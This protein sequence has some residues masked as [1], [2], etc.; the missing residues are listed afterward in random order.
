[1]KSPIFGGEYIAPSQDVAFNRSVNLI[2]ELVETREGKAV[3]GMYGAPGYTLFATAGSGPIRQLYTASNGTLYALSGNE[4]YSVSSAG[5]AAAQGQVGTTTGPAQMTDNGANNQVLLVDGSAGWCLNT[6]TGAFTNPL[7]GLLGVKP[8]TLAYQ[9]GVAIV[10]YV[11]T[12]QWYQSNLGDLSTFQALNFSSAD[13]TPDQIISTFDI[14]REVW[15]FKQKVIEVWVNAGLNGFLFQRLQG[16]Q[17]PAGCV[18]PASVAR[19]NDSL[20]WLGGDEQGDGVVYQSQSYQAVPISTHFIAETI[21]DM[22]VISD[23][24]GFVE[25]ENQHWYYWLIFPTANR[26]FVYDSATKLWHERAAFANGQFSRHVAN[27]HAFAYRKHLIGDYTTGNIYALNEDVYTDN[28]AVHKWLRTWRGL[29]PNQ[30]AEDV[31]RYEGL[32]IDMGTGLS[33]PPGTNPHYM[34]RWS[35]DGG[36]TWSSEMWTDGNQQGN[37][38]ARVLFRRLGTT[39]KGGTYDRIFELSGTDPVPIQIAG[40]Y[41]DIS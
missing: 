1:M 38:N 17:I 34:L 13:S 31:V 9:D 37:T 2:P 7:P 33:V 27:C 16:V 40:A 21:Q 4:L 26:T 10:N 12:N 39:K 8:M 30:V 24:I 23:A 18:A 15:L 5:A 35:D 28:G 6:K 3:G 36:Y 20:V 22:P 29:P 25:Q 11:G 41:I 32:Q 14:H 19:I